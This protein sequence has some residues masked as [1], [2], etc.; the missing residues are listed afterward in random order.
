MR[1]VMDAIFNKAFN[2]DLSISYLISAVYSLIELTYQ[3]YKEF[4]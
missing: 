3:R 1:I 4:V 2:P